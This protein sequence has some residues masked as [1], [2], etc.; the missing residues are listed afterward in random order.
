MG[1][2]G[3]GFRKVEGALPL[4]RLTMQASSLIEGLVE[5]CLRP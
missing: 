5:P 2:E 4:D 1:E 3:R